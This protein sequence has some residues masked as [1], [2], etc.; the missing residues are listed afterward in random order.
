MRPH[1]RDALER[2][3]QVAYLCNRER[4]QRVGQRRLLG[5]F[6]LAPGA[7][8]A[9]VGAQQAIRLVRRPPTGQN[10]NQSFDEFLAGRMRD[11]FDRQLQFQ[12]GIEHACPAQGVSQDG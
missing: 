2:A 9:V 12:Q 3:A 4:I 6:G 10:Q 7:G 1:P 11:R 8:Q 5:K